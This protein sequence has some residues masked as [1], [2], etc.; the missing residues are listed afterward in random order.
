MLRGVRVSLANKCQLLFGLAVVVILGAALT[1]VGWRM[2]TLVEQGPQRRAQDLAEL[3]LSGQLDFRTREQATAQLT[4]DAVTKVE[5]DDPIL[6]PN[7][8]PELDA[9]GV[10]LTR[11]DAEE[12]PAVAN[13]NTFVATA[14]ERFRVSPDRIEHFEPARDREGHTFYRYARALRLPPPNVPAIE[15]TI[16]EDAE[17]VEEQKNEEFDLPTADGKALAELMLAA[18]DLRGVLLI[19]IRDRDVVL[20]QALN[21]IYTIAAWLVAGG[22]AIVVFWLILTRLILSPVRV[23]RGYALRVSEGDLSIRSDINTGDEFEQLSD[24][25]NTMLE[26]L[27]SKQDQLSGVNKTLDL[28][29]VEM[30]ESNIALYEANKMKGEFLANVSHEL[31]TPLN[32]II[33]FAEVLQETLADR[34]GP[35][36]EKRKRY[37][38]N[39]I[40]SSRRLLELINDLLDLAKIEAGRM[41][42]RVSTV[43]VRDTCEGLVALINPQASKKEI[44]VKLSVPPDLPM[45]ETDAGKLQQVLFNFLSNAVKFTPA[46]GRITVAAEALPPPEQPDATGH[47]RARL[48]I[49]VTD[50]GPGIPLDEQPKVFEKF[51]QLDPSVTKAHGGTG[52]GLTIS[53]ELAELLRGRISLESEPGQGATFALILPLTYYLPDE[54]VDGGS[55]SSGSE[56]GLEPAAES[57][58]P[59]PSSAAANEAEAAAQA[60]PS[61]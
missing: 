24:V 31:R 6:D 58:L 13:T 30:A 16:P 51:V 26:T 45:I 8:G 55:T 52:L 9:T 32:S 46:R 29:L 47:R 49:A 34:T 43:S 18:D 60:T 50:T 38:A 40:T 25:F 37:A 33:G 57:S 23:L 1:V 19:E 35:V 17:D 14:I 4:D 21:R 27:K 36:D 10:I 53:Q 5:A 59:D 56:N 15:P 54:A 41:D 11:I 61:A 42:V 7:V 48:R 20:Q 12:F 39:I 2:Q 22:L 3:Y 44:D 28:K